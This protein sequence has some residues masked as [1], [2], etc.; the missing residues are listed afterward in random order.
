MP[1]TPETL[2]RLADLLI[3]PQETLDIE[4]KGW[5]DIAS[6]NEHRALLAKAIIALANHGGGFIIVGF[7]ST[8]NGVSPAV[9]RPDNL[10]VYSPDTV[11]AVVN[12][13]IEPS[14]HCEVNIVTRAVDRLAYPIIT[15]PGGH[16]VPVR[17][18]R[19]GPNG[20]T[21]QQNVY[22]TRRPG[23]QSEPPQTGHEWDALMR[24]CIGNAREDLLNQFRGILAGGAAAVA[25][26][27][28]RLQQ[29]TR[30]HATSLERWRA[31]SETLPAE[32]PARLRHGYY[33]VGYQ[34]FGNVE[35]VQG[36]ALLDALNRGVVRH[37]GWPPFWVPTRD[38]IRPYMHDG[39]VECWLGPDGQDRDPGHA[40][41]WRASPDTQFFLIRGYQ[42]DGHE[43]AQ[44][45][46]GTIF[47]ITL[48]TWRIGEILLHAASMARQLGDA[49]AQAVLIFEWTGLNGRSL[50]SFANRTR[51]M[52][53]RYTA[54]Q[55]R[56]RAD[57]TV[58]ADQIGDQLPELVGRV[59]RPLYELFD[60]FQL[61]ATLPL[62]EL[63]RMRRDRF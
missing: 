15:V 18:K 13:Y 46:P 21:I 32:H 5:L 24:R 49:Q 61:P 34:L 28:N 14:F 22:Y 40:D 26:Q 54:R 51:H 27:E 55:E 48:P 31:L 57:L 3:D 30:W 7:E 47:D 17:S 19:S 42:E 23:P 12:R 37:T 25:P 10:A 38:G 50:R 52:A 16:H 33:N 9:N 39:N 43:N 41:F 58:Q 20:Q 36:T 44:A 4:I 8:P 62:E 6:E 29:V 59:I 2:R 63:E 1:Q 60:F 56:Y 11:N 53:D 45:E 35:R